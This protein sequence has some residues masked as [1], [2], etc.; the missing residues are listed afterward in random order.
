VV[1]AADAGDAPLEE[2]DV[3]FL[4]LGREDI[5]DAGVG[6]EEVAGRVA[7]G[8]GDKLFQSHLSLPFQDVDVG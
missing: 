7:P 5:D 6:Q 4:D 2:D 8:D 3:A 1:A